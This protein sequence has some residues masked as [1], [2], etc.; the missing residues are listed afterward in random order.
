MFTKFK[1]IRKYSKDLFLLVICFF[2]G[3]IYYQKLSIELHNFIKLEK[4]N[5]VLSNTSL[6]LYHDN[7][8]NKSSNLTIKNR[9]KPFDER[10]LMLF[11]QEIKNVEVQSKIPSFEEV[12]FGND[13]SKIKLIAIMGTKQNK[14][15]L[16]IDHL[17]N[18]RIFKVGDKV[19]KNTLILDITE[20][21]IK[22]K[23]KNNIKEIFLYREKEQVI[24]NPPIATSPPPP[25]PR[26]PSVEEQHIE[27][28]G[29]L[30]EE[31]I[32]KFRRPGGRQIR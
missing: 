32:D 2:I 15:A 30:M 26:P 6:K 20:T 22:F 4:S 12:L 14:K 16:V 29:L 5:L 11:Q 7:D 24:L 3:F 18:L 25:L 19:D 17:N 9:E 8:T 13:Y 1:S 23:S 27:D 31:R 28:E 10:I 21:S